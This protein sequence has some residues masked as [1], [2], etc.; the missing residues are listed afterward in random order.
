LI[1]L[2]LA[3]TSFLLL[4]TINPSLVLLN[5]FRVPSIEMREDVG[6]FCP[7]PA[8]LAEDS[9]V[10]DSYGNV[11]DDPTAFGFMCTR[12]YTIDGAPCFG[13]ICPGSYYCLPSVGNVVKYECIPNVWDTLIGSCNNMTKSR[14]EQIKYWQADA[15]IC[16]EFTRL[17]DQEVYLTGRCVWIPEATNAKCYWCSDVDLAEFTNDQQKGIERD[18]KRV[19]DGK[20]TQD[21]AYNKA[22]SL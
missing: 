15:A 21:Q 6:G 12:E 10:K 19:A 20:I 17:L 18:Q 11:I 3:L 16:N 8:E 2:A 4:Y 9:E 5:T 7:D 1:G 13:N 22:D 14:L